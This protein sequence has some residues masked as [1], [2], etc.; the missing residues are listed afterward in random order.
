MPFNDARENF[1]KGC[2]A[3]NNPEL[4]NLEKNLDFN[5]SILLI[6]KNEFK[7]PTKEEIF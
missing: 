5:K 3:L 4:E 6:T 1:T 2:L 7:K